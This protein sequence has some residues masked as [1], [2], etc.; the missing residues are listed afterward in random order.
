MIMINERM[1]TATT[2]PI[3]REFDSTRAALP[4]VDTNAALA[5]FNNHLAAVSNDGAVRTDHLP[6]RTF[7]L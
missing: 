5:R 7:G 3:V 4:V 1:K 6:S 2:S